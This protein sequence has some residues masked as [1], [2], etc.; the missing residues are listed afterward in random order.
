MCVCCLDLGILGAS[1]RPRG[2]I[3]E[4]PGSFL[5]ASW[6]LLGGFPGPSWLV[7]QARLASLPPPLWG[8]P[9]Y[10][11]VKRLVMARLESL[12]PHIG[13]SLL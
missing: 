1:E 6:G 9:L 5:G 8:P 13:E 4:P 10:V 12:P 2:A 7:L 3:L 11:L